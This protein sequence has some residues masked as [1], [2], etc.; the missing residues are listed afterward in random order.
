[1]KKSLS[2][3]IAL[4]FLITLSP[5]VIAAD[6]ISTED[7]ECNVSEIDGSIIE[8][9]VPSLTADDLASNGATAIVAKLTSN[10]G[11]SWTSSPSM[12]QSDS[13][14]TFEFYDLKPEKY[15]CQIAAIS[16]DFQGP[17]S[18]KGE[19]RRNGRMRTS[20][21]DLISIFPSAEVIMIPIQHF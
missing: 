5:S 6:Q 14:L 19:T 4:T 9:N 17:W 13:D 8:I 12:I 1:M 16:D 21:M 11:P 10:L 20:M 18:D 2:I 3:L 7:F 15:Y